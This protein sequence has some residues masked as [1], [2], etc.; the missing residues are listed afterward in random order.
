MQKFDYR[1]VEKNSGDFRKHFFFPPFHTMFLRGFFFKVVKSCSKARVENKVGK[2]ENAFFLLSFSHN[3]FKRL[4]FQGHSGLGLCG[5]EGIMGKAWITAF[6]SFFTIFS[7]RLPTK[8][9]VNKRTMMD[10]YRSPDLRGHHL[11]QRGRS[12]LGDA[13]VFF[14]FFFFV[15][16]CDPLGQGQFS[17]T[18]HYLMKLGRGSLKDR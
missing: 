15:R 8:V 12:P 14:K 2:G 13:T 3:V 4:I 10:L 9:I 18:G 5:K 1:S 7:K 6:S 16:S 17:S 11:N